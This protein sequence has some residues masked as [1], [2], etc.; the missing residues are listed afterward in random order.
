MVYL[1][2]KYGYAPLNEISVVMGRERGVK[3][4]IFDSSRSTQSTAFL[5]NLK[6]GEGLESGGG[7]DEGVTKG[8]DFR[9]PLPGA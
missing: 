2:K 9:L 5:R 1:K 6:V 7:S 8:W 4:R 3:E